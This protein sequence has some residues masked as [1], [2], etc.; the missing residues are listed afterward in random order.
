MSV[1]IIA[2]IANAHQGKHKIAIDIA[3]KAIEADADA[4]KFQVYFANEFLVNYHP[5]YRH[6]ANKPSEDEGVKQDTTAR[7]EKRRVIL[8]KG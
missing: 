7:G 5:R 4:I 8:A 2:E 3:K 1:E 6:F